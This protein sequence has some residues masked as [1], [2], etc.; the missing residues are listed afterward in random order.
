M[1]ASFLIADVVDLSLGQ[2]PCQRYGTLEDQDLQV[3]QLSVCT[4]MDWGPGVHELFGRLGLK[5][6]HHT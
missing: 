3:L 4:Y 2:S 5:T 1:T 6:F